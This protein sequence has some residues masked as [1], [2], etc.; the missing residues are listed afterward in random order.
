MSSDG[1]R[2]LLAI[3][4][5]RSSCR[6]RAGRRHSRPEGIAKSPARTP[7]PEQI[8]GRS[9][10]RAVV[11]STR[12]DRLHL[13]HLVGEVLL[14]LRIPDSEDLLGS[15]GVFSSRRDARPPDLTAVADATFARRETRLLRARRA[16]TVITRSPF[17]SRP[18]RQAEL[19]PYG[20][21]LGL[22]L[23]Q[24]R[25]RSRGD[26]LAATRRCGTSAWSAG[27]R[28]TDR[29]GG[30]DSTPRQATSSRWRRIVRNQLEQ[31]A[32]ERLQVATDR[33]RTRVRRPGR[34]RAGA[35]Q[36]RRSGVARDGAP[37]ESHVLGQA[38]PEQLRLEEDA[39]FGIA[40]SPRPR[41]RFD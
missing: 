32:L 25:R 40:F 30:D 1:P 35:A 26:V 22:G 37:S 31:H 41:C 20:R 34:W 7:R 8:C 12:T 36:A 9:P 17:S 10:R 23:E 24:R 28:L 15:S 2:G 19:R 38:P 21:A 13:L 11:D 4:T 6:R 14:G 3:S 5:E 18:M 39:G 29:L 33:P 16:S 27:A